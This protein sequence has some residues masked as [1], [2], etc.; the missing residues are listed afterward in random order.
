MQTADMPEER[1]ESKLRAKRKRRVSSKAG[2]RK[3]QERKTPRKIGAAQIPLRFSFVAGNSLK[4]K[5]E[6]KLII[7]V[8]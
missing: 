2:R 4:K 8:K 3:K 6:T 5:K 1:V 7:V